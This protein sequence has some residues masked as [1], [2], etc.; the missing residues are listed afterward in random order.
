MEIQNPRRQRLALC[1]TGILA[2]VAVPETVAQQR[3]GPAAGTHRV[4]LVLSNSRYAVVNPLKNPTH[5][6]EDMAA[7]LKRLGFAVTAGTDLPLNG[8]NQYIDA[9]IHSVRAG[10]VALFYYAGHG[11]QVNGENLLV[12]VDYSVKIA[13]PEANNNC[14]RFDTVQSRMEAAGARL[15]ILVMDACRTNPYQRSRSWS[16]GM[17][18]VEAGLGSYIAFSA[19]PGQT[20]DDNPGERNGLFTK[21]L[22]Q[23]LSDPKPPPLSQIF[24]RVRDSVWQDSGKHQL[25]YLADQI[26]GDFAFSGQL[27]ASP[28]AGPPQPEP[29]AS[30]VERLME[31]GTQLYRQGKCS[32]ALDSFLQAMKTDPEN[33]YAQNSVGMAYTCMKQPSLAVERFAMAVRLDPTM[34]S[35]YLNRGAAFLAA[36]KYKLAV[37]DFTWAAEQAPATSIYYVWRGQAYFLDRKYDEAL[38]DYNRAI[39]LDAA[40]PLAFYGRGQVQQR[41]GR[42]R[43]AVADYDAALERRPDYPDAI[44]S[45]EAA[46]QRLRN[47]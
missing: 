19:S 43:E 29:P 32:Q 35:A 1:L 33:A 3:P 11:M 27:A 30:G 38:S 40:D 14:I 18:P 21:F 2:F 6:G 20:A 44:R 42:Y 7:T 13:E 5:D 10:D 8:M 31:Q 46:A 16:R 34:A 12:P 41:L 4:A 9:F 24:R 22:V 37:E 39:E 36:G 17:A 15:A 47:R 28:Q 25:P 26:I 23:S 45:R